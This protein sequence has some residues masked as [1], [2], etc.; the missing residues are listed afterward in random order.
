MRAPPDGLETRVVIDALREGWD[1][2]VDVV[3]YAAVGAGSYHWRVA[4]GFVTVDHLG[5]KT[6]LGDTH[7]TSFEGLRA[8]FDTAVALKE[9]GLD[10]VVAPIL[11]RH[12]ES[13][14][15]IDARYTIALF[16]FVDGEAGEF[17]YFEDDEDGRRAVVAMLAELHRAPVASV[18]TTGFDLPGR[19][20]L[21]GALRDLDEPWSG[22][23]LSEPARHAIRKSASVLV[24]LLVL[25]D[26]LCAEAQSRAGDPVVTHGEPHA[27][28]AMRTDAGY[29]LVDWDTVALGPP[30]RDLW[31][32]VTG[33]PDAADLYARASGTQLDQAALDFFRLTWDLKDL[34]E[35]LNVFRSPHE[36]NTDTLRQF[37]ALENIGAIRE[38]WA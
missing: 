24:E 16:P 13:L 22:G 4:D 17:G 7:D 29:V 14:R 35:Y 26:R 12:G 8:A 33:N 32:L 28:N 30:E 1:V 37:G 18:R 9:G 6:W 19:S 38:E 20:H 10:F 23:P 3:E 21:E 5:Q 34:A 36:E 31:M 27:A 25:A 11:S 15:R 2:D